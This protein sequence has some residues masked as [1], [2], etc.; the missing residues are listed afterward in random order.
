[1]GVEQCKNGELHTMP[2]IF[3]DFLEKH[4]GFPVAYTGSTKDLTQ[5]LFYAIVST[6][7]WSGDDAELFPGLVF[8][9]T[10]FPAYQWNTLQEYKSTDENFSDYMVDNE[11]HCLLIRDEVA[12]NPDYSSPYSDATV[13][14]YVDNFLNQDVFDGSPNYPPGFPETGE[15]TSTPPSSSPV[16]CPK[17]HRKKCKK[18]HNG[19]RKECKKNCEFDFKEKCNCPDEHVDKCD[20]A[21]SGRKKRKCKKNCLFPINEKCEQSQ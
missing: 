5:R 8:A 17:A 16:P 13:L 21:C 12:T 7:N 15:L 6:P 19:V 11:L 18:C 1:M 9:S 14:E 3:Q 4:P 20:S 10:T 2:P